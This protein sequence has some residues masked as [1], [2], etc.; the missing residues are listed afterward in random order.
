MFA[1][2]MFT[3]LIFVS[4]VVVGIYSYREQD[5]LKRS[6]FSKKFAFLLFAAFTIF[7]GLFLVGETL[8]DPGGLKGFGMVAA[9]LVPA[10]IAAWIS[11][12]QLPYA[13]QMNYVLVGLVAAASSTLMLN[14]EG[15]SQFMDRNGPILLVITF[16]VSIPLGLWAWH[17]PRT[18]GWML[19]IA[20]FLPRIFA[21]IGSGNGQ[22][23]MSISLSFTSAP[24]AIAGA[25]FVYS[26]IQGEQHNV[27]ATQK[28]KR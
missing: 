15:I 14:P 22:D 5:H 26:A 1:T 24:I 4:L 25:L 21:A 23:A 19:V 8:A 17:N 20:A 16:A 11:W 3:N 18:G 9:W 7:I 12:K 13:L 28:G 2:N 27:K 6:E 10:S